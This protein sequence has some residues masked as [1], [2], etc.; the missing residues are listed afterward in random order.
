MIIFFNLLSTPSHADGI[1]FHVLPALLIMPLCVH[2]GIGGIL[3][4]RRQGGQPAHV[5]GTAQVLHGGAREGVGEMLPQQV[6]LASLSG[7]IFNL[8]RVGNL[9]GGVSEAQTLREPWHKIVMSTDY[10]M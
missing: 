7:D 5:V 3:Q 1:H 8:E 6:F 10:V 2:P 4:L 9:Q